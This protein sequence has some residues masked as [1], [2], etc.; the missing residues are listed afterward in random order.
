MTY[1][2][3]VLY[4]RQNPQAGGSDRTAGYPGSRKALQR[5]TLTTSPGAATQ[6]Y[7]AERPEY[8]LSNFIPGIF[9]TRGCLTVPL[10]LLAKTAI[11]LDSS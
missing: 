3:G 4:P 2:F 8:T 7:F 1:L 6:R 10:L 11:A 5:L 9:S